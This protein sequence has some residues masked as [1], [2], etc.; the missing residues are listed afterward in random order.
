MNFIVIEG[1][2]GAGT[3]TQAKRLH[4][5][6]EQRQQAAIVTAEPS[7]GPIGVMIRDML[8]KRIVGEDGRAIDRETLA[9]LFAADRMHH[10][11]NVI[12]PALARNVR[13]VS[14]RYYPSSIVY[15]GDVDQS[16]HFDSAWVRTLNERAL[17]PDVTFFIDV[18]VE[19]AFAR[20]SDR[21]HRDIYETREKLTRLAARYAQVM[22]ML[23]ESGEAIVTIDGTQA[24]EDVHIDIVTEVDRLWP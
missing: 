19:V 23:K 15:Q 7:T 17:R 1:L 13:V 10:C 2:D 12:E 14:D 21:G 3:T 24:I 6:F 16:D 8:A 11:R 20:L 18:P 4:A 5:M 9:L 22:E